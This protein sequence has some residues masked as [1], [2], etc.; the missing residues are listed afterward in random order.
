MANAEYELKFDYKNILVNFINL[1][2]DII[3]ESNNYNL[4]YDDVYI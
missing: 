2:P 4:N 1:T 3:N